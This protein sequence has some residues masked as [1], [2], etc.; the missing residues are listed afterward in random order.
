M[1]RLDKAGLGLNREVAQTCYTRMAVLST[2]EPPDTALRGLQPF[3]NAP[4]AS[5]LQQHRRFC[6]DLFVRED[7]IDYAQRL[8][9]GWIDLMGIATGPGE[10]RVVHPC[11]R[12]KGAMGMAA[13]NKVDFSEPLRQTSIR[14]IPDVREQNQSIVVFR[15]MKEC[16]D[17]GGRI[18]SLYAVPPP[19]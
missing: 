16:F 8:G 14:A 15:Q 17:G 10:K 9:S 3:K 12:I 6:R 13:N 2:C 7:Q 1:D 11:G 5:Q 4:L 18:G 19:G